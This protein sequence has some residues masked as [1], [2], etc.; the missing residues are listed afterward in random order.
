MRVAEARQIFQAWYIT[1]PGFEAIADS[2]LKWVIVDSGVLHGTRTA[3]KWLQQA[4]GVTPDGVIGSQTTN[5]LNQADMEHLARSVLSQ[6]I[7]RYVGIVKNE[8]S[9]LRF[10]QGWI[11]RATSILQTA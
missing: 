6:R 2:F 10:L 8:P 5:A 1:A 3:I 11:E 7:R 4:L 9:Q